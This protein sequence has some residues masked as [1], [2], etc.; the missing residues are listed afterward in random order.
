VVAIC[1][2]LAVE[3]AAVYFA[4][5]ARHPNVAW[6]LTAISAWALWWIAA[7]YRALG[8]E[9]V[10]LDDEQLR[11]RI[12][13]RHDIRLPVDAVDAVIRPTFR[14]LP[15]PGTRQGDDYLNLTKPAPPNVLVVL[16][17]PTRIRLL[18]GVHRNIRRLSLRL[19]DPLAFVK[20][21][22]ERL[23]TPVKH[24]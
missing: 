14:D 9:T 1:A 5:A 15:T 6:V 4:V 11:L 2:A 3:T 19:D 12:G 22:A 17:N 20:A 21:L 8:R 7:D 18:A 13:R 23:P 10:Q 24:S 16:R